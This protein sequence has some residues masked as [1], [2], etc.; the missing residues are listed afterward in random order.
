MDINGNF[1]SIT[2]SY[3]NRNHLKVGAS[4]T[5]KNARKVSPAGVDEMNLQHSYGNQTSYYGGAYS[6][7]KNSIGYNI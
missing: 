2:N 1:Y 5:T 6:M 3:D 7:H 4:V